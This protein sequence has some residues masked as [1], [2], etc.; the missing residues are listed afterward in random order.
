MK[1]K[2][3]MP[4]NLKFGSGVIKENSEDFKLGRKALLVTGKNSAR[5]SGAL[6]D[7]LDVLTDQGIS[8]DIFD[9]VEV[10]PESIPGW[11]TFPSG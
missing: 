4:V 7:I 8:F 6:D 5:L 11:A 9:K 1:F 10:K 3:N 2:F